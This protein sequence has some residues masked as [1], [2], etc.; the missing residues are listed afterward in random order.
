MAGRAQ[1][2][3]PAAGPPGSIQ[4][5]TLSHP[6]DSMVRGQRGAKGSLRRS[7]CPGVFCHDMWGAAATVRPSVLVHTLPAQLHRSYL[8]KHHGPCVTMTLICVPLA[9]SGIVAGDLGGS[10]KSVPLSNDLYLNLI[11]FICNNCIGVTNTATMNPSR[12][13]GGCGAAVSAAPAGFGEQQ[14]R[15]FPQGSWVHWHPWVR[16]RWG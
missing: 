7:L 13:R 10:P 12:S 1:S 11:Q 15:W 2:S 6:G 8:L 3:F 14:H 4:P 9:S 16:E 5:R